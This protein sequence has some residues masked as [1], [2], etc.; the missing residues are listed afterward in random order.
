MEF[1]DIYKKRQRKTI[2]NIDTEITNHV[3][4]H[5]SKDLTEKLLKDWEQ[6]CKSTEVGAKDEFEKKVEWFKEN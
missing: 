6:E 2:N 1:Q 4:A 3:A 5:R